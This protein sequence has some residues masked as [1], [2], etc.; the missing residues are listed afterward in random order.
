MTTVN[1]RIDEKTK[2][3]ATKVLSHIGLDMSSAVKVFLSQVI[4]E[5]G[6]PFKPKRSSKEIRAQWD[7]DIEEAVKTRNIFTSVDDILNDQT[8]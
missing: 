8:V 2:A 3:R 6:L 1:V 5:G 7:K 4:I